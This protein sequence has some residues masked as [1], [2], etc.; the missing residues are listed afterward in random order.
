MEIVR[1]LLA[2]GAD[3][4]LAMEH[5]GRTPLIAAAAL[6]DG[7]LAR[8]IIDEL[9]AAGADLNARSKSLVS[10]LSAACRVPGKFT[11]TS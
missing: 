2:A 1:L 4:N 8:M 7:E 3:P 10:P 11:T 5:T 9:V 6:R